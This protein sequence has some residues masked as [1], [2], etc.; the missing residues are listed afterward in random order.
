M[1]RWNLAPLSW[2]PFHFLQV[3]MHC[4]LQAAFQAAGCIPFTVPGDKTFKASFPRVLLPRRCF[5][6]MGM[7]FDFK[8]PIS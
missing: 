8:A 3:K 1:L 7:S 5:F 6:P 4:R 2:K